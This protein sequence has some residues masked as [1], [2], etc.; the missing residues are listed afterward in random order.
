MPA[1]LESSKERNVPFY[2]RFG[3]EVIE[4]LHSK[5]GQPAHLAHVARAASPGVSAEPALIR[6][7]AV[8]DVHAAR[9]VLGHGDHGSSSSMRARVGADGSPRLRWA[10]PTRRR[11]RPSI[12]TGWNWVAEERGDGGGRQDGRAVA[13]EGERG[14]ERGAR[15]SPPPGAG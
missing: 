6:A 10:T 8:L 15:R 13:L 7:G 1:Y 11:G 4:E 14:D 12:G 2:A 3:F 9:A 5:V